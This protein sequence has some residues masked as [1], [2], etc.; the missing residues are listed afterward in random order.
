MFKTETQGESTVTEI[1]VDC[2]AF[3][4]HAV[5]KRASTACHRTTNVNS[6]SAEIPF[7]LFSPELTAPSTTEFG[8]CLMLDK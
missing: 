1:P 6:V 5:L 7:D 8:K 2:D 3:V 4:P